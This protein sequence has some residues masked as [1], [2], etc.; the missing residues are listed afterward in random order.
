MIL[1]AYL[2]TTCLTWTS[3]F[4]YFFY[5]MVFM[6]A[7]CILMLAFILMPV[8][9]Y[10]LIYEAT[11]LEVDDRF[12]RRHFFLPAF[13]TLLLLVVVILTPEEVQFDFISSHG[14]N[15][16][17]SIP[18]FW[19]SGNKMFIRLVF[20]VV[21]TVLGFSRLRSYRTVVLNYS[22]NTRTNRLSWVFWL[23]VLSA[24]LIPIPL[25]GSIMERLKLANSSWLY[26]QAGLLMI[27]NAYLCVYVIHWQSFVYLPEKIWHE[28]TDKFT[29]CVDEDAQ[30][31]SAVRKYAGLNKNI[32]ENYMEEQ[33]PYL[34]PD[35]RISDLAA[36]LGVNRTYVS[37]FINDE[38]QMN[39]SCFIN[40]YRYDAFK[41]LTQIPENATLTKAAQA[42][43]AGFN[44]LRSFQRYQNMLDSGTCQKTNN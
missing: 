37:S 1:L 2:L 28:K 16:G 6:H 29:S 19:I 24:S 23:L 33:K 27:Q 44:S 40:R 5:P 15:R 39:F 10:E 14:N 30:A 20:S 26:L 43:M 42:E 22:S 38:F 18:F 25:L 32:L 11:R 36:S 9:L 41:K 35:L 3:S 17:K 8:L 4:A 7:N 34:N 12:K 21:Y 31:T 13:I